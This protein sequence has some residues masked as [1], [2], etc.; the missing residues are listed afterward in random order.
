MKKIDIKS[1]WP[2]AIAI[3]LFLGIA[4]TYFSPLLEGKVINQSDIS[5]WKGAY[6]EIR[7]YESQTGE[8]AL[9]TNS[10]FS[11]MPAVSIGGGIQYTVV[12]KFYN[13]FF[14][15]ARPANDLFLLLFGFYLLLLAF[16]VN[17]WLSIVGAIAF[18]FC[19]YNFEIIQVG[20]S[21]KVNTI[22][23][24]PMVFAA[25]VY[26]Y[27]NNYLLGSALFGLAV[28]FEIMSAHPQITYYLIFI[29]LAYT[30]SQFYTA[31][32]AK[33]LPKFIKT[34]VFL[35]VAAFLGA[36]TNVSYLWPTWEYGKYTMRGGSELSMQNS[37]QATVNK[38]GL[39]KEYATSWSYGIEESA[40]LLI[41]NFRG[42]ASGGPLGKN[43]ETYKTL[44][45]GGVSNADQM[46]K[47]MPT[48][49]GPQAFT[50]GPMYMGAISIF[51]FVLG[52]LL[53]KGPMKWWIAAISALAL[54]LG[55]GRHFPL[56][57]NLFFDYVPL[58]N[59]FR[60]PSM[61]LVIL[62]IT[63]PLLGFYSLS[64]VFKGCYDK[65]TFSRNFKIALGITAG[66]CA[67][68]L[69]FP[70]IAGSFTSPADAQY[71]DWL[72]KTLPADR[73]SLL[74]YDAFR[75]LSYI[76]LGALTVWLGYTQKLK[77]PLAIGCLGLLILA[78]MW[79]INKRYLNDEHFVTPREFNN[80]FALRPVDKAILQ[81]ASESYRVLDLAVNT[82]NDSHTSFHHKTIGGYSAVKLQRYQDLIDYHILPEMQSFIKDLQQSTT[83]E[84]VENSLNKQHVLNMLN[85]KYIVIDPNSA[86]I[87]NR[88]ALGNAWFVNNYQI[89]NSP[90]EEILSLN[91][92]NPRETAVI[93]KDFAASVQGKTFSPDSTAIIKLEEYSLNRLK[94]KSQATTDQLAVFSE[95]YY[96]K[97]WEVSIDGQPSELFRTDYI[98]RGMIVPAGE[99]TITFEYK[100]ASYY[101]GAVISR[102]C[103]GILLLLLGI[104]FVLTIKKRRD[105]Q[106]QT[107]IAEA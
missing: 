88:S 101:E 98:L 86:P 103:T 95:I 41:P 55:W 21:T 93:G 78:D 67:L 59:K 64:K 25:L 54:L 28:A 49:W 51:L 87:L 4:L 43:S 30:L 97:G 3:V 105:T 19:S 35:A 68:F 48:Y 102:I 33:T 82:F 100:P 106:K 50:A 56:V 40:N 80:N 22:A 79:T 32:K 92:I 90:D 13:L 91:R 14:P 53:V 16:R 17:P 42:G 94:Y 66:F 6:E 57:S 75:S 73:E 34:S 1:I 104:A 7:Q 83:L 8:N 81:D 77:L 9:W 18:A 84:D 71:P 65:K 24:A 38:D 47:Q 20:H 72:Q 58:Y 37:P 85:A 60:V 45:R 63:I 5:S 11:G 2:Y 44:S 61:I 15:L 107:R 39:D 29:L 96:P 31:L 69:V 27:R 10:M 52:L 23:F 26:A 76:A 70:G 62:Q 46:I 89:V 36:G 99:H 12:Q 74:R